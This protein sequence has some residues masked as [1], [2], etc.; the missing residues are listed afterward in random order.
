M[1]FWLA[2]KMAIKSILNNK[3]RSAL[4]MLGVIIGVAAVIA[5]VGFAQ[6]SM[7][8]VTNLVQ[9]MGTNVITAMIIDRSQSKSLSVDDLDTMVAN[10]QYIVSVSPYIMTSG[11]VKYKTES[12]S[13][14]ITGTNETYID[15]GDVTMHTGRFITRGDLE[16]NQKVAVIGS[17]VR[18]KLFPE[19]D[20]IGKNI[21]INGTN[22]VVVVF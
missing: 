8:S 22:F 5:A 19:E 11:R 12:K 2:Y 21:K 4:T 6:G 16:N 13:T 10:S 20:P 7:Q 9:G 14:T 17:G 15:M 1:K 18:R 3:V